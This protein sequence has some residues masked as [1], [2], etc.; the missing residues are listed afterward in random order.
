MKHDFISSCAADWF[1]SFEAVVLQHSCLDVCHERFPSDALTKQASTEFLGFPTTFL[2]TPE[3]GE[4]A[5]VLLGWTE[6]DL[7]VHQ[8][9][10][11]LEPSLSASCALTTSG[12]EEYFTVQNTG[13]VCGIVCHRLLTSADH[14]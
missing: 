5:N 14:S 10:D 2:S 4:Q 9:V 1:E 7:Y 6:F 8:P 11:F 3:H 13:E 12:Q